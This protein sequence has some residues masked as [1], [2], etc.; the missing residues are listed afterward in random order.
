MVGSIGDTHRIAGAP[1][2]VR[3][4]EAA[5]AFEALFLE[6]LLAFGNRPLPGAKLPFGGSSAERGYRQLFLQEV[7]TRIASRPAGEAPGQGGPSPLGF[8]T[9]IVEAAGGSPERKGR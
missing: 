6:K 3:V 5:R 9:Q 4:E 7:A 2:H 1:Q 8:A